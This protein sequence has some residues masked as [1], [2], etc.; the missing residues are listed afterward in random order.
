MKKISTFLML[1]CMSVFA[2][3]EPVVIDFSAQ[4][5]ENGTEVTT[6]TVSGVTVAFDK[7]S[8]N[9]APKYYTAGA[10]VRVY[11]GGTMTVSAETNIT[12]IA[13][14]F[15]SD[16]KTNDITVDAGT[17]A[18]GAW[19]GEAK[20][21]VFTVGGTS[22]H[23]RFAKLSV[24]LAEGGVTPPPAA[25]K[26][27][28][29][30][31][32][33]GGMVN[34]LDVKAAAD[35]YQALAADVIAA[36]AQGFGFTFVGDFGSTVTTFG[37][38]DVT[39]ATGL[40]LDVSAWDMTFC[41]SA[42]Y[43][44]KWGW[45]ED[46]I[47]EVSEAAG[48]SWSSSAAFRYALTAFFADSQRPNWPASADYKDCGISSD[49]WLATWGYQF[50]MPAEIAADAALPQ[51]YR[52]GYDFLG[53]Y[54]G[55][56]KVTAV[57]ADVALTAK[58]QERTHKVTWNLN[59]GAA[60]A[61]FVDNQADLRKILYQELAA[62]VIAAKKEG[63]AF[64]FVGDFGSTVT[65]FGPV[66][67]TGATGLALDVSAWDMTFCKSAQYAAKWGWL[68]D[69]IKEVSEAAGKSWNSS[70]A[71]RYAL[72][73]FF[74]DSQRPNWPASAD[75]KDCGISSDKWTFA[76][77]VMPESVNEI[78]ALPVPAKKEYVFLGWYD[79]EELAGN[80]VTMVTKDVTLYAKWDLAKYE[81]VWHLNGGA[82]N[83]I[84]A[85]SRADIYQSLAA[86][87]LEA[88]GGFGFSSV[89]GKQTHKFG[90]ADVS[91]KTGVAF[92]VQAWDVN[93]FTSDE[94]K[95]RWGWL[96]DYITA[97]STA[98]EATY[99]ANSA[100]IRYALAAFFSDS[101]RA[102]WP[103]SADFANDGI[104][105][106]KWLATWGGQ[107]EYPAQFDAEQDAPVPS[108]LH[109]TF[110]G[111][112]TNPE[113]TGDKVTKVAPKMNAELYAK[114]VPTEKAV[115]GI[116]LDKTSEAIQM[117]A[118]LKITPSIQP[119]TAFNKV[120]SW[121]VSDENLATIADSVL[122]PLRPGKVTVTVTT[123]EGGYEAKCEVEITAAPGAVTG[124][125]LSA[126]N[127]TIEIGQTA[128]LSYTIEPED[129][130]N[131]N[132]SFEV[133]D[134]EIISFENGVITALKK[135]Q[136]TI[137]V[138]TEDGAYTAKCVV[139]VPEARDQ[140]FVLEKVWEAAPT[141]NMTIADARQGMGWD[142]KIFFA[143]KKDSTL[144]QVEVVDGV[145]TETAIANMGVN[146]A[147]T[148][149]DDAGNI[150]MNDNFPNGTQTKLAIL[151]KGTN[152]PKVVNFVF[153]LPNESTVLGRTDWISATG[154]IFSAEGGRVNYYCPGRDTIYYVA[155]KNGAAGE[156]DVVTGKY[157]VTVSK[158]EETDGAFVMRGEEGFVLSHH[159]GRN[160]QIWRGEGEAE[161]YVL[162]GLNTSDLG[163]DIFTI[164][165]AAGEDKTMVA[166]KVGTTHSSEFVVRNMTD[167]MNV[168]DRDDV[169]VHYSV[170]QKAATNN[171]Y[172]VWMKPQKVND[173]EY[174]IHQYIPGKA[175]A[176]WHLYA[177][178]EVTSITL[179][180]EAIELG[181]GNEEAL[182]ATILPENAP[183]KDVVWTSSDESIAT[184]DVNGLV[185]AVGAGVATITATT[186]S[187]NM[188]A[189]C[190]VT[191]KN[192]VYKMVKAQAELTDGARVI[193]VDHAEG[194]RALSTKQNGNNRGT[195]VVA[196]ADGIIAEINDSVQIIDLGLQDDGK[197]TLA[198]GDGYLYA[199]SDKNNWLRTQ[200]EL[201]LAGQWNIAV[202]EDGVAS[203]ISADESLRGE[204]LKNKT[205]E[206]F[207]CYDVNM[208]ASKK[209]LP[210]AIYK[211]IVPVSVTGVE[212]VASETV[213]VGETVT[214][215]ATVL[216][217]DATVKAVVWTSDDESVATVE[218]GVVTGVAEGQTNINAVT[219]DGEFKASCLITVEAGTGVINTSLAGIYYSNGIIYN[220]DNVE[221]YVYGAAGQLVAHG[222]NNINMS[223]QADGTYVVRT[224]QGGALKL[225]K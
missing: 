90:A 9:N 5:Y 101:K 220:P 117:P 89:F 204:L 147:G 97:V 130:V 14:E 107:F 32:L 224:A 69:Y 186:I 166:Y 7:G 83:N 112:Y 54:N 168:P 53:W 79:N 109:W 180:K 96:N 17:Y 59:G 93:F 172:A 2:F 148:A 187:G 165:N 74:A 161:T 55:D 102:S 16:D 23:R 149:I 151:Q 37:P 193:I 210:V 143:N 152:T 162:P 105:S 205:Q 39:G 29:T 70:A 139:T 174:V 62:D 171:S 158:G 133:S 207:S 98:Q 154:D 141:A 48:K 170:D 150:I 203:I 176:L 21:V 118:T 191:V 58:W 67:V 197:F 95:D 140:Q 159:R 99:T 8:N 208:D 47:K 46:Y 199:A 61:F 195:S 184:V 76:P 123:E 4:A 132:V 100:Q 28:V 77:Y 36:K 201:T 103:V 138:T 80:P 179:N 116:V 35:I 202:A 120:I 146:G 125:V 71:F 75:Y 136:A 20:S 108:R 113:F 104:S 196:A 106:D 122:T 177:N 137:T 86:D 22:G 10:A 173:N 19:S 12:A 13:L 26:Y 72:T 127:L 49:K 178:I 212:M 181:V 155:I 167:E 160:M 188:T 192:V 111:W 43:A 198:V 114:W 110:D 87:I 216:P 206:L 129:A 92:D 56:E 38:V 40:A 85:N 169:S 218:D 124:V 121:K 24:T 134:P 18:D 63:F 190:E 175:I 64:T 225:V 189:T 128:E 194:V 156:G 126:A 185:K 52:A 15:G 211:Q 30:W 119:E 215:T 65:T 164:K 42:Q 88:G 66:D 27:K 3:A 219:V 183:V 84:Y 214:L 11:G 82:P 81:I 33:D 78:D 44:A 145:A 45:L 157:A 182:E 142:G 73:A 209:Q 144:Y 57:S 91:G 41:K 222:F 135:G 6:L 60:N 50:E 163:G 68:E 94:Y 221:L 34:P 51:V 217:A 213:K 153:D 131:K 31:D 223:A 115:T 25:D 1:L 200:E